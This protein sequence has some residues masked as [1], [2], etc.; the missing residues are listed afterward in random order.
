MSVVCL[1]DSLI[2][3]CDVAPGERWH[4]LAAARLEA[5]F[6]NSGIG[7]DTSAGLLSRFYPD[8]IHF[9]VDCRG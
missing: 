5:E 4:A 1:G 2:E 7:G 9:I 8:V 6:V 3:G